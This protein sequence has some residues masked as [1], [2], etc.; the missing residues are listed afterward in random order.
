MQRA[1]PPPGSPQ[2]TVPVGPRAARSDIEHDVEGA[3]ER[4]WLDGVGRIEAH[5]TAISAGSVIE[6]I[7]VM[8]ARRGEQAILP[9][10][11][12]LKAFRVRIVAVTAAQVH[13][14][15]EGMSRFGKGR[16]A[17]PAVLNFGDLFAYALARQLRAE[18]NGRN[19]TYIAL[20]GYG[21]TQDRQRGGEAG[22]E[23]YLVKPAD[24]GEL[25]RL[26]D[27]EAGA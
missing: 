22:F 24:L 9:V 23:H 26:L 17:P 14:A 4:A 2:V 10:R 15:A 11:R 18:P 7:R 19:A 3:A 27:P 20:T 12:F 21:S 8:T 6:T 25:L 13:F 5:D 16:S 1:R